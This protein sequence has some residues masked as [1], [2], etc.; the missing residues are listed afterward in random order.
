MR[1]L[2]LAL[3]VLL[4]AIAV[5]VYFSRMR[6]APGAAAPLNAE[7]RARLDRLL[8]AAESGEDRAGPDRS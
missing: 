8:A 3:A 4:G 2:L 5:F 6:R 7:E 1:A